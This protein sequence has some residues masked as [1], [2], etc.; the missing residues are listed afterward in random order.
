MGEGTPGRDRPRP[1]ARLCFAILAALFIAPLTTALAGTISP[2]FAQGAH[3]SAARTASAT[4]SGHVTILVIDS[5]GSMGSPGHGGNDPNGL[6]CSAAHAYIDL[7]GANQWVGLVGLAH[8]TGAPGDATTAQD[9][10]QPAEMSTDTARAAMRKALDTHSN[11][12]VGDGTT[13]MA[14]ALARADRMLHTA[15][16]GTLSGSVI[17][18]TDG[19][20]DPNQ[21]SQLAAIRQLL[22]DFQSHN[23]PVDTIALGNADRAFLSGLA[24][25]TGGRSFD[26]RHGPVAGDS[27]LNLEPF[28]LSIFQINAG[29]SL[30][31]AVTPL[32]L[33]GQTAR[34]LHVGRFV[35]HMDVLVV[36]DSANVSALLYAP[37]NYPNTPE[38]PGQARIV[39]SDPH[40]VIYAIDNPVRGD[41]TLSFNGSGQLLVDALIQSTLSL[42]LVSPHAN[43]HLPMGLGLAVNASLRDGSDQVLAEPV[44]VTAT[45]IP[46]NGANPTGR[47]VTLTDPGGKSPTG[48]Y[49]GHVTVPTSAPQGTYVIQ[50]QARLN[51]AL[52]NLLVPVVFEPFPVPTLLS[53]TDGTAQLAG[54]ALN[55]VPGAPLT[56]AFGLTVAGKSQAEPGV[57]ATLTAGGQPVALTESGGSWQGTYVPSA[58]GAQ[59]LQVRLAGTYHGTDLAAWPYTLPLNITLRPSLVVEGV[60]A[61]RPYP[62]HRTL[63]VTL[64]YF[65]QAGTPDPAAAGHI[66]AL[67]LPP[68]GIGVPLALQPA[69]DA[70]GQ[71]RPGAF[72]AAVPFGNTGTYTLRAVFDDGVA[73]DHSEQLFVLRVIDFPTPVTSDLPAGQTL[74][75][76]GPL[77]GFYGLPV[78]GWFAAPA[79]GGQPN[80]PTAVVSGEVLLSGKPFAAGAVRAVAYPVDGGRAIPAE[81]TRSGAAYIARF[82]PTGPGAYQVVVTWVG[83]FAGVRADQEPTTNQIQ[84]AI[85]GPSPLGWGQ[86][87]LVTLLYLLIALCL[88]QWGRFSATPAPAG[89]LQASGKPDDLYPLDRS[90]AP[91]WRRFLWRN[92]LRT[93]DIGLPVGA[94]LR[95]RRHRGPVVVADPA[96]R[97]ASVAVGGAELRPGAPPVELEGAVL[98]FRQ[99]SLG[100]DEFSDDDDLFGGRGRARGHRSGAVADEALASQFVY[101]SPGELRAHEE[102]NDPWMGVTAAADEAGDPY[103]E[104]NRRPGSLLGHIGA[105]LA[106]FRPAPRPAADDE[107]GDLYADVGERPARGKRGRN[108]RDDLDDLDDLGLEAP[109]GRRGGHAGRARDPF[110]DLDGFGDAPRARSGSRRASQ[111]RDLD[112]DLDAERPS[113]GR[114]RSQRDAFDDW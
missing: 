102:A 73:G 82:H 77:G 83:D 50:L 87:W 57:S 65:R 105:L 39:E 42:Q 14:D 90:H 41:W 43:Q 21:S 24:D 68:D 92:R 8:P 56:V 32:T 22:P 15:T 49:Q 96:A 71:P 80:Q 38:Q 78:L 30:L 98:A 1:L 103:D 29:R 55:A 36:R 48:N 104:P 64:A 20:P 76:W 3:L 79:L 112:G 88:A 6:R 84:V 100:L 70:K 81:V 86:A 23:W 11:N 46:A 25:A 69:L 17:L 53:P 63:S 45:L 44:T 111:A 66:T 31:H 60:D 54:L 110:D 93:G 47:E 61:R 59:P 108:R 34:Q 33:A 37:G 67:L 10:A 107:W 2:A 52:V 16:K 35:A 109:R 40:Y 114:R 7:S 51:D 85:V 94:E 58:N 99:G 18:L 4:S 74:T 28:F 72:T 113:R 89:A 27:P 95:F 12:C 9:Y 5:S 75:N 91:L 101:R 62:A 26:V 106:I 97:D 13:P 19:L